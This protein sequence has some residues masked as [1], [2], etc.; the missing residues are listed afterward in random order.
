MA[1][2]PV[3]IYTS[4]DMLLLTILF[5]YI[6]CLSGFFTPPGFNFKNGRPPHMPPNPWQGHIPPKPFPGV[7]QFSGAPYGAGAFARAGPGA[8]PRPGVFTGNTQNGGAYSGIGPDGKVFSGVVG[9]V[10]S[11]IGPDGKAYTRFDSGKGG[12]ISSVGPNG[13]VFS[14]SASNGKLIR[15]KYSYYALFHV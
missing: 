6:V 4:P 2:W 14:G 8:F 15:C 9:G 13:Q 10:F 5:S 7:N 12:A 11:G 3:Q 1:K